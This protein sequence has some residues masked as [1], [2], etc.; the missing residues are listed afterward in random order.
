MKNYFYILERYGNPTHP[1][2]EPD[3]VSL[4]IRDPIDTSL[5]EPVASNDFFKTIVTNGLAL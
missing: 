4:E 2:C 3:I 5:W 1:D